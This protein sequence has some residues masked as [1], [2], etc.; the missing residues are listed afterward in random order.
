MIRLLW[1]GLVTATATASLALRLRQVAWALLPVGALLMLVIALG[2]RLQDFTT[3]SNTLFG[4]D[5]QFIA[6]N[7][8]RHDAIK[9]RASS[10]TK[11]K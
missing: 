5:C 6:V 7:V 1:V 4:A 8:A 2:T 10:A 9:R 3:A 11:W